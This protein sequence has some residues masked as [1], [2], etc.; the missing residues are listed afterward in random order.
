MRRTKEMLPQDCCVIL[1]GYH[2]TAVPQYLEQIRHNMKCIPTY[3]NTVH[4]LKGV[5]MKLNEIENVILLIHNLRHLSFHIFPP[6]ALYS[7]FYKWSLKQ[8]K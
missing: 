2:V 5:G 4:E 3:C 8:K 7:Q 6:E 1:L